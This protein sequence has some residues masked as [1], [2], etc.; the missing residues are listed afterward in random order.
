MI[1]SNSYPQCLHLNSASQILILA[2]LWP[3]FGQDSQV[4][5]FEL[6][7]STEDPVSLWRTEDSTRPPASDRRRETRVRET[8]GEPLLRTSAKFK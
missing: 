6:P 7:E 5:R 4:F 8:T 1:T 3:Q 2:T